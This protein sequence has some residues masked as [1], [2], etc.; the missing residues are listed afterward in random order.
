MAKI[1]RNDPCPCGSGKKYKKCCMGKMD[2][3]I[4]GKMTRLPEDTGERI[5]ALPEVD[6][7][8]CREILFKLD[9]HKLTNGEISVKFID[10]G[11]YLELGVGGRD[12]PLNLHRVSAAQMV[13]PMKTMSVDPAHIYLA[14]SPAI[15]DS[16]IIHQLAHVMDYLVGSKMSPGLAR[17]LSLELEVPPEILEHT[18]EFG[19]WLTHMARECDVE[20]DAE[21][22]IVAFL[23]ENGYLI[24]GKAFQAEDHAILATLANRALDYLKDNQEE[25]NNRIKGRVGYRSD[26]ASVSR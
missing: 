13:N 5:A 19:D 20:L 18:K 21:D 7:G 23:H 2:E 14:V 9:L 8:R 4:I 16:T 11:D 12:K 15:S 24:P 26:Q 3:S 10:L 22:T 25:I 6:Y 1:G 17:P